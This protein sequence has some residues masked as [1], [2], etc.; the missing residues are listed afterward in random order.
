MKKAFGFSAFLL[1][2]LAVFFKPIAIFGIE[3]YLCSL[4]ETNVKVLDFEISKLNLRANIKNENNLAF[5]HISNIYPLQADFTYDGNADAFAVYHTIKADSKLS[6]TLYYKNFLNL[7]VDLSA[8]GAKAKVEVQEEQKDWLVNADIKSLDLKKLQNENNR[9]EDISGIVNLNINFHTTKSSKLKITA[10]KI[11]INQ[12]SFD[13]MTFEIEGVY[14]QSDFRTNFD[15]KFMGYKID[16]KNLRY[17][18]KTH[19]TYIKKLK[20]DDITIKNLK[21]DFK[22]NKIF[23]NFS[24]EDKYLS[25]DDVFIKIID[26]DKAQI[27]A[28]LK[29]PYLKEIISLDSKIYYQKDKTTL[30]LNALSNEFN[31]SVPSAVYENS[32]FT[33]KYKAVVKPSISNLHEDVA[34]DG[35]L[36]YEKFLHVEVQSHSFDGLLRASLN[37]KKIKINAEKIN[38]AKVLKQLKQKEYL[39]GKFNLEADGNFEK[40]DFIFKSDKLSLS[41]TEVGI[42]ENL[43]CLVKGDINSKKLNLFSYVKNRYIESKKGQFSY[44]FENKDISLILPMIVDFKKNKFNIKLNAKANLLEDIKADLFLTHKNDFLSFRNIIYKENDIKTNINFFTKDLQ[45]YQKVSGI[46][47]YGPFTFN[48]NLHFINE[49]IYASLKTDALKGNLHVDLKDK[50]LTINMKNIS[51]NKFGSLVRKKALSNGGLINAK[52]NYNLE[53]EDGQTVI[54]IKNTTIHGIDIDK[55]LKSYNDILGLNI[56]SMGKSLYLRSHINKKETKLS[57][58]VKD[59]ELDLEINKNNIISKDVAMS[60]QES[61]FA[62]NAKIKRNGEIEELE[63]A[64][65]DEKGCAIIKQE[66][67]G[68]VSAPHLKSTKSTAVVIIGHAPSAILNTGG[69]IVNA[70]ANLVDSTASYIWKKALRR[71]SEV[72]LVEDALKNGANIFSSGKDILVSGD[73]EVFYDGK[74]KAQNQKE[75]ITKEK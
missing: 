30:N 32:V 17:S 37:D 20:I 59:I 52:I 40:L 69:K 3:S 39:S 11:S 65:L 58:F 71:E 68:Q 63:V 6:G 42:D 70:S 7:H 19:N 66:L 47:L 72:T 43:S 48:G 1:V 67:S 44:I 60:T 56:Y 13:N 33:A 4:L 64:I 22:D 18:L 31:L 9:T 35:N 61:R 54:N 57:T 36:R 50:D 74:V 62:A 8:L 16:A 55:K 12:E 23:T 46:E 2:F 10:P 27:K 34:M 21:I 14:N 15:T 45:Y 75:E 41:K 73:C 25:S 5:V 49:K 24:F 51:T 29:T 26:L 53:R 28:S 38:I